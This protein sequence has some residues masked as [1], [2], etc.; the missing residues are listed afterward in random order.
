[1][2]WEARILGAIEAEK[3]ER[4]WGDGKLLE[5]F[6]KL[7]PLFIQLAPLF[8]SEEEADKAIGDGTFI[9]KLIDLLDNPAAITSLAAIIASVKAMI[10]AW[11]K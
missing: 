8:F 6:A 3:Q 4:K 7:L 2:S 10:D 1:M 5:L 9:Q 11:K